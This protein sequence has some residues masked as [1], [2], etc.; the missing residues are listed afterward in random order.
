MCGDQANGGSQQFGQYIVVD[1]ANIG[2]AL[3]QHD[4][5]ESRQQGEEHAAAHQRTK[6][7]KQP[8]SHQREGK[9]RAAQHEQALQDRAGAAEVYGCHQQVVQG[10]V[11]RLIAVA[12]RPKIRKGR[13]DGR[14]PVKDKPVPCRKKAV[15]HCGRQAGCAGG[16]EFAVLRNMPDVVDV[17][18]FVDQ[19]PR[20]HQNRI[21]RTVEDRHQEKEGQRP[22]ADLQ[23]CPR[24]MF[25]QSSGASERLRANHDAIIVHADC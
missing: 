2:G 22:T 14:R 25:V 20:R 24:P 8:Y 12:D 7:K 9:R 23:P 3:G 6:A 4:K 1:A 15:D 5:D 18:C 19:A 21:L 10:W 17:L 16:G 13:R 11:V